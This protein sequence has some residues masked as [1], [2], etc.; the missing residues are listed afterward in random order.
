MGPAGEIHFHEIGAVDS[1]V[2]IVGACIAVEALGVDEIQASPPR[3][4]SGFV[5]TAHRR[6][7]VP[8]PA[9]LEL[10]KGIPVRSSDRIRRVGYPDGRGFAG[11]VLHEVFPGRCRR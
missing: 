9:T 5:E 6:F 1:I 7:P 11:G 3:L 8:A 2:D 10:L 4:G